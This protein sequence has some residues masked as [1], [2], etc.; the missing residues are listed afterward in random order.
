MN[1]C[2]CPDGMSGANRNC[3]VHGDSFNLINR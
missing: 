3:P 1:T 2:T